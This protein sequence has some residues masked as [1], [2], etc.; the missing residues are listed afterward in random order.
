MKKDVRGRSSTQSSQFLVKVGG[1]E[2]SL[3]EISMSRI[4]LLALSRWF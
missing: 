2:F 4:A 3:G 1:L